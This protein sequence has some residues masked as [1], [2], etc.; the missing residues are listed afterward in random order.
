M[1][2]DGDSDYRLQSTPNT[3]TMLSIDAG[4]YHWSLQR[5]SR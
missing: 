5:C 1:Q 3:L 2:R 4:I